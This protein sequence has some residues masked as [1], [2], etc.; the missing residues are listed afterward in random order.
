[1]PWFKGSS[2][3]GDEKADRAG[4]E[5]ERL[6]SRFGRVVSRTDANGQVAASKAITEAQGRGDS[7]EELTEVKSRFFGG[8]GRGGR[9]RGE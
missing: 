2:N 7:P 8:G 5:A 3:G 1:V 9:G 6:V 4:E